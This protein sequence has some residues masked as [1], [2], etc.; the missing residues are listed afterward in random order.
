MVR[1]SKMTNVTEH[2]PKIIGVIFMKTLKNDI[3]IYVKDKY[4]TEPDYPWIDTPDIAILDTT[5]QKNGTVPLCLCP[6][7]N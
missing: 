2:I 3:F 5:T 7:V 4:G 6:S 1:Y